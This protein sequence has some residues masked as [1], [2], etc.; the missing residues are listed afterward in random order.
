MDSKIKFSELRTISDYPADQVISALQKEIRQGNFENASFFCIELLES[1]EIF[2][3]KF[4]ERML[5]I[6]VEDV[7]DV[8]AINAIRNLKTA[9]F[10]L[11]EAKVWDRDMQ[12]IKAVQILC[13]AK[14][15]RIVS[16]IYDY[17]KIKRKDGL[18]IEI[19][20]YAIDM[21]TKQGK[22]EGKDHLHFLETSAKINNVKENKNMK[23]LNEL[24]AHAKKN[25][26]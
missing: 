20:D 7:S 26:S 1:G 2:V 17:L 3:N 19:P 11:K 22:E 5:V 14:K 13:E 23:Y 6:V 18:K 4:W 10:E 9:Y 12:A 8:G 24:I 21:H 15:D 25:K 16:E